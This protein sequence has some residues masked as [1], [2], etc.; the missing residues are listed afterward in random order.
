MNHRLVVQYDGAGFEGF[1][2]QTHHRTIQDELEKALGR[3]YKRR[4]K[5]LGTSRTDSGVHALCQVVS[6]QAPLIIPFPKL[7]LALNALLPESIRVIKA[8]RAP[9]SF[10]P[11]FA[12]K[13][14]TYE[15][16]IF[17]GKIMPPL[18][19]HFVWQVK[20]KLDLKAMRRA[21]AGLKGR[22]DFTAFCNAGGKERAGVRNLRRVGIGFKKIVLWDG[23]KVEVIT[24]KFQA[25]GFL[26]RMVRNLVGTLVEAGLGKIEPER[27]KKIIKNRDRTL[28]GRTAPPQGLCLIKV[29]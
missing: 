8:D 17:N 4:I 5:V 19:R 29:Q 25:D 11:R 1:Q 10:V 18:I 24:L 3:L 23:L 22:H 20:P 7:P 9:D 12:A 26:Y 15:Y 13:N 2:S 21:A 14:K 16:L 27:I 28:A 6:F